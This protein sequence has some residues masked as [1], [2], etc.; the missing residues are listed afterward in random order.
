[1]MSMAAQWGSIGVGAAALALV[2]TLAE[3]RRTTR[4]LTGRAH[5]DAV[6]FMPWTTIAFFALFTACVTL[7][8]AARAWIA[9]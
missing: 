4:R 6:G 7:G 8:L 3:R 2:S 9:G 5:P 1:M